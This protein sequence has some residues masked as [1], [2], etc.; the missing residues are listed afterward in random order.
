LRD[1]ALSVSAV[2]G[3]SF[4][5]NGRSFGHVIDPRT[6]WPVTGVLLAAVVLPSA[7]EADAFSTALLTLGRAG[8]RLLAGFRPEMRTLLVLESETRQ[9]RRVESR[10]IAVPSAA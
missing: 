10:G 6:G 9:R 1:E 5:A 4:E 3:R 7:T 8:H 2:W